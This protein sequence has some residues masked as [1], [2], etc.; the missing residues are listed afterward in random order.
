MGNKVKGDQKVKMKYS[1][2]K[3]VKMKSRNQ[4]FKTIDNQI[5]RSE[6]PAVMDKVFISMINSYPNFRVKTNLVQS[7][8]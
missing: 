3:I 7:I 8:M 6:T 1:K 2:L 5:H 4:N